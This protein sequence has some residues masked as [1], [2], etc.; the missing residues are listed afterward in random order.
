MVKTYKAYFKDH[1]SYTIFFPILS[2]LW[3]RDPSRF[4][5]VGSLCACHYYD[6][7]SEW[8]KDP[9]S[10]EEIK[11]AYEPCFNGETFCQVFS[12]SFHLLS[13][14]Y[15]PFLTNFLAFYHFFISCHSKYLILLDFWN[16]RCKFFPFL[17]IVLETPQALPSC[18]YQNQPSECF[19]ATLTKN[20]NTE[21][22]FGIS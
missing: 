18:F 6:Y 21:C 9:A 13:E 1:V 3:P 15:R 4:F 12:F 16:M 10:F 14:Q 5:L 11:V 20:W 8:S 22:L 17:R 2:I 7:S 19:R